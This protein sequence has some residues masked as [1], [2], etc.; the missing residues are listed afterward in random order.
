M[1]IKICGLTRAEDVSLACALGADLCGFILAPSPRRIRWEQ[2]SELQASLPT[3][4]LSVAVLVDPSQEEVDRALAVVD[5]VQLHGRESPEFCRRYGRRAWKAFRIR[6][7]ADLDALDEYR[8]CVGAFLLDSYSPGVA[9]GTGQTFSW[10]YLRDRTFGNTTF[11]AGGLNSGN[12]AEAMKVSSV[13]GLDVSSGVEATP[14]CKD[15][16]RLRQFFTAA[17]EVGGLE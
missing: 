2:L 11:L 3:S 12:V 10:E 6:Q 7:A 5:R 17:R 13:H 14:G 15:S 8:R 16:E 1:K 9:G 4:V